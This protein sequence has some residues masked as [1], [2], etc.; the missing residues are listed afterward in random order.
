MS[1]EY[2]MAGEIFVGDGWIE[3]TWGDSVY[4]L[5]LDERGLPKFP[6]SLEEELPRYVPGIVEQMLGQMKILHTNH[7]GICI[8]ESQHK[9]KNYDN[10][11][12]H[13]Q[14]PSRI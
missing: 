13:R 6:Q 9:E 11:M 5:D 12:A 8:R 7:A 3:L 2:E 10:T 4:K 1:I 14:T